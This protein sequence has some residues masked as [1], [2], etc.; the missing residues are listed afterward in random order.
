MKK[1]VSL[2]LLLLFGCQQQQVKQP[3]LVVTNY[4]EVDLE[5]FA[6]MSESS[7]FYLS[8]SDLRRL[9]ILLN[10]AVEVYNLNKL[11]RYKQ[12]PSYDPSDVFY[13]PH[14]I[15]LSRYKKQLVITNNVHGEKIVHISAFTGDYKDWQIN[16]IAIEDGGECCFQTS[17]NLDWN[18]WE[19]FQINSEA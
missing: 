11:E 6:V 8:T 3:Q 7:P 12:N 5:P 2:G 9:A 10:A 1:Y 17:I 16:T 14:M 15:D 18:R 4:T 13:K 19:Y